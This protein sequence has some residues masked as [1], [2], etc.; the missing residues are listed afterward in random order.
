MSEIDL[1]PSLYRDQVWKIR[2][3]K[4]F[5]FIFI[6]LFL[7]MSVSYGALEFVKNETKYEISQLSKIKEITAQQRNNLKVLREEKDA[8][9]Y[10]WRLLSGL[11]SAV[12]A[13]DLFVI[14]DAAIQDV[15]IW[16]TS[17]I[18]QRA[19]VEMAEVNTVNTGYYLIVIPGEEN[20]TLA[21]G[22]KMLI[23]GEASNH[24]T[25]SSFVN[26]LLDQP[27][28][29]DAK[30]LETSSNK[31]RDTRTVKFNLVVTINLEDKIS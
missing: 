10:Q 30:V 15:D 19:E 11:K 16:F 20:Q 8:L 28:I 1:I 24:S 14:I 31:N 12:N 21:I 27:E 25:L 7:I 4:I 18:F 5:G 13:E 6:C 9:D 29:L 22:T 3:L 17:M 2:A 26:N 23:T